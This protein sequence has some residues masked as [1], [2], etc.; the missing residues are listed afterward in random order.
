[1]K[2]EERLMNLKRQYLFDC[3]CIACNNDW[4]TYDDSLPGTFEI[5]E[6]VTRKLLKGDRSVVMDQLPRLIEMATKYDMLIP[7]KSVL[8]I[9]EYLKQCYAV[10][11]N[12][13][14]LL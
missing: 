8:E 12:K 6:E 13:R 10:L 2:K 7:N 1:M 14:S 5:D 3:N 4:P 9:Q 11:A